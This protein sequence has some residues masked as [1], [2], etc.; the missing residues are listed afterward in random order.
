MASV[1]RSRSLLHGICG[2]S[3]ASFP[4]PSSLP[5]ICPKPPSSVSSCIV[6]F[7]DVGRLPG[8]PV[9]REKPGKA[10]DEVVACSVSARF[11]SSHAMP[12]FPRGRPCFCSYAV[13]C[14]GSQAHRASDYLAGRRDIAQGPST[15]ARRTY[16]SGLRENQVG[17]P[18]PGAQGRPDV[19]TERPETWAPL[20]TSYST[21]LRPL[22]CLVRRRAL[23]ALSSLTWPES[24]SLS[25]TSVQAVDRPRVARYSV[26][27]HSALPCPNGP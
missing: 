16:P 27:H 13:P 26:T 24:D 12:Q 4:S 25:L 15:G 21:V 6:P 2:G 23:P 8:F 1:A 14:P 7:P 17:A 9:P 5:R 19:A 10:G 18:G 11:L 22:L 20:R 3:G